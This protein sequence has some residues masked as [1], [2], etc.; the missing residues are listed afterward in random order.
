MAR[1]NQNFAIAGGDDFIE[2]KRFLPI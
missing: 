1:A 2:A